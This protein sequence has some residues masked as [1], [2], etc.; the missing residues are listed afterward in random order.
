MAQQ[1]AREI[2]RGD[3]PQVKVAVK[4]KEPIQMYFQIGSFINHFC[5][6]N[7]ICLSCYFTCLTLVF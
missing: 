3:N 5:P 6:A 1:K 4:P 7:L 2:G